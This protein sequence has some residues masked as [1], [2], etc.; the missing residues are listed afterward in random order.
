MVTPAAKRQAVAHLCVAYEISQR[1]ACQMIGCDR[2]TVRYRSR[3]PDDPRLRERLRALAHERRRFGYRR[4]IVFLRRE[5]FVVNHKRLFRI[6]R[7]EGL[8]VRKR[9]GRK[10]AVGM[11]A[12]MP[13]PERPNDLW[14]MDFVSDQLNSG[15]RFR[16]WAVYDVCTRQCVAALA[17]FSLSGK[18]VARELDRLIAL[19]GKPRAI[20][21]DNGTEL[22]SNAI[23]TWTAGTG[24]DWHYIDPGKPVQNAFIESFNGRLR[25][26]FLNET[27]FTSLPQARAALEEWQCDY[28]EVRPH[29]RIGWL[30]PAVYAASFAP[31]GE[32]QRARALRFTGSAPCR[33]A[34]TGIRETGDF[35]RQTQLAAG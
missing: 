28:N 9:K 33:A 4:L 17:D 5:G 18:R 22:T 23:L 31:S 26:E 8:T 11:R 10:R 27:L 7:E 3:R 30:A 15:R 32:Q 34:A 6:Y 20:V 19:L 24:V 25:D 29:S 1:R 2:M 21:S 35:N 14:A 16:I 13:V 12:P